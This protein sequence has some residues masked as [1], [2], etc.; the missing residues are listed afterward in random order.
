MATNSGYTQCG[1]TFTC[2]LIGVLKW[3]I[4]I[5]W[6]FHFQWPTSDGK[7]ESTDDSASSKKFLGLLAVSVACL[8]SGFS[9]VYFEKVLKGSSTSVWIRNIQLGEANCPSVL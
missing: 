6:L 8:S 7:T 5:I 3:N 4:I 1:C 9:G 2:K